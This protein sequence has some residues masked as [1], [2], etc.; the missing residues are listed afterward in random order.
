MK[1]FRLGKSKKKNKTEIKNKAKTSSASTDVKAKTKTSSTLTNVKTKPITPSISTDVK[2]KTMTLS[3]STDVKTKI[4]T[5]PTKSNM[6][7]ER[8]NKQEK[9]QYTQTLDNSFMSKSSSSSSNS[10]VQKNSNKNTNNLTNVNGVNNAGRVNTNNVVR[11]DNLVKPIT[12]SRN[13]SLKM[14]IVPDFRVGIRLRPMLEAEREDNINNEELVYL[15]PQNDIICIREPG[16]YRLPEIDDGPPPPPGTIAPSM[17]PYIS[18]DPFNYVFG[19]KNNSQ[20]EVYSQSVHPL[21]EHFLSGKNSLVLAYGQMGSGKTY[22]IGFQPENYKLE[23]EQ[24]EVLGQELGFVPRAYQEIH[25]YVQLLRSKGRSV[26]LSVTFIAI[27]CEDIADLLGESVTRYKRPPSPG[28]KMKS[29]TDKRT[30]TT[31]PKT[32][33]VHDRGKLGIYLKGA[34]YESVDSMESLAQLLYRGTT[35][36]RIVFGPDSENLSHA[37][38]SFNL[39]QDNPKSG[40]DRVYSKLNFVDLSCTE[41]IDKVEARMN[42]MECGVNDKSWLAL[43]KVINLLTSNRPK[44]YIP[45]RDSKLTQVLQDSLSGDA[46]VL[47]LSCLTPTSCDENKSVLKYMIR[48]TN[49]DQRSTL[50][51]PKYLKSVFFNLEDMLNNNSHSNSIIHQTENNVPTENNVDTNSEN[52]IAQ[53]SENISSHSENSIIPISENVITP[54]SENSN[55]SVNQSLLNEVPLNVNS[56]PT[57]E[58]NDQTDITKHGNIPTPLPSPANTPPQGF[59]PTPG[60]SPSPGFSPTPEFSTTPGLSPSPNFTPSTGNTLSPNNNLSPRIIPVPG[61]ITS[62]RIIPVHGN[63]TSPVSITSPSNITS[64]GNILPPNNILSSV[65]NLTPLVNENF[66]DTSFFTYYMNQP[67]D[68]NSSYINANTSIFN[69]HEILSPINDD[70]EDELKLKSSSVFNNSIANTTVGTIEGRKGSNAGMTQKLEEQIKALDKLSKEALNNDYHLETKGPIR[71]GSDS[72]KRINV[73]KRSLSLNKVNGVDI[74]K[75]GNENVIE[76]ALDSRTKT[77]EVPTAQKKRNVKK[78]IASVLDEIK[79]TL[80]GKVDQNINAEVLNNVNILN[81]SNAECGI[82]Q[83]VSNLKILLKNYT[84]NQDQVKKLT[85]IINNNTLLDSNNN[86]IKIV[87]GVPMDDIVSDIKNLQYIKN[88]DK[89]VANAQSE[90]NIDTTVPSQT[91]STIQAESPI[92]SPIMFNKGHNNI[93]ST[94]MNISVN[95]PTSTP[96][97]T[98]LV[99]PRNSI[100]NLDNLYEIPANNYTSN[101]VNNKENPVLNNN[102]IKNLNIV[103]A[104]PNDYTEDMVMEDMDQAELNK[105]ITSLSIRLKNSVNEAKEVKDKCELLQQKEKN[106]ERKL[107]IRDKE[108]EALHLELDEKVNSFNNAVKALVLQLEMTQESKNKTQEEL[109]SVECRTIELAKSLET[110]SELMNGERKNTRNTE[111]KYHQFVTEYEDEISIL[112]GEKSQIL[113]EKENLQQQNNTLQV[114]VNKLVKTLKK[115]QV[116]LIETEKK[117][118]D[119]STNMTKLQN[120]NNLLKSKL[121]EV[122]KAQSLMDNQK[123]NSTL[124]EEY[125]KQIRKLRSQLSETEKTHQ[126]EIYKLLDRL[127]L[128][129]GRKNGSAND[130]YIMNLEK[131]LEKSYAVQEELKEKLKNSELLMNQKDKEN[132]ELEEKCNS[133]KQS[134]DSLQDTVSTYENHQTKLLNTNYNLSSQLNNGKK[135]KPRSYSGFRT[136]MQDIKNMTVTELQDEVVE[137]RQ[138]IDN[139]NKK[140]WDLNLEVDRYQSANESNRRTIM[141]LMKRLNSGNNNGKMKDEGSMNNSIGEISDKSGTSFLKEQGKGRSYLRNSSASSA[142]SSQHENSITVLN[143]GIHKENFRKTSAPMSSGSGVKNDELSYIE[144]ET[145]NIST[146][147]ML[148]KS[149]STSSSTIINLSV[150]SMQKHNSN[151]PNE[152]LQNVHNSPASSSSDFS[153]IKVNDE[154]CIRESTISTDSMKYNEMNYDF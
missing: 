107:R 24:E 83:L 67:L 61:N 123:D 98:S 13:T 148:N 122:K 115:F 82:D 55:N 84:Q 37:I 64:P 147:F 149:N 35:F 19:G 95:T 94:P 137:L 134:I 44:G 86:S 2:N 79:T 92:I 66:G 153:M 76:K 54:I 50:V 16:S 4:M 21:V 36:R 89:I 101:E 132:K 41:K 8:Q 87:G 57:H 33:T 12:T 119:T 90:S 39:E 46:I 106:L 71:K 127:S 62:P 17:G 51:S 136:I 140:N 104:S 128:Y 3:A 73:R 105:Y 131:K 63:I 20:E 126:S 10:Q 72:K 138:E 40:K 133:F 45:Y 146:S 75:L 15:F 144:E 152:K 120:E 18:T 69:N 7:F 93:K 109:N 154:V 129:E 111:D 27:S 74:G 108:L 100:T 59:T 6:S 43:S 52:I 121:E 139:L 125:R 1:A 25:N 68:I 77:Y 80:G 135:T 96:T 85:A 47:F 26:S 150:Y 97:S 31:Q 110:I 30:Q 32:I 11:K 141:V 49:I 65:N 99:T 142:K 81:N 34:K 114:K 117:S 145:A 143:S 102:P 23:N 112:Q 91:P 130:H 124:L 113:H 60:F 116:N 29:P 103:N 151:T 78:D 88:T 48:S 58:I 42:R 14:Q 38:L 9:Q 53:I 56:N 70:F 22:T 5:S 118:V 28:P